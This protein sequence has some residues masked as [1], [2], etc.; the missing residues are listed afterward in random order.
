MVSYRLPVRLQGL[1][2][3]SPP[4]DLQTNNKAGNKNAATSTAKNIETNNADRDGVFL[5]RYSPITGRQERQ[6]RKKDKKRK[7]RKG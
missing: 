3:I 2:D 7:E 4:S 5:F 6:D 1:T